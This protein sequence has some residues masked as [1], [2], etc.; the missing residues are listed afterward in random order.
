MYVCF[1]SWTLSS[2]ETHTH[3]QLAAFLQ[4]LLSHFAPTTSLVGAQYGALMLVDLEEEY[5]A[6][7]AAKL[8]PN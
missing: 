1:C 2:A 7:K 5:Y 3:A 4:H 6:E 8:V